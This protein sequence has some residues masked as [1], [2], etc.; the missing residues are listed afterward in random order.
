MDWCESSHSPE[1]G[2]CIEVASADT[3][4]IR[5]TQDRDGVIPPS[6]PT[7]GAR[8]QRRPGETS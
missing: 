4:M 1:N 7:H 6:P 5:E 3:V 8:S 2:N